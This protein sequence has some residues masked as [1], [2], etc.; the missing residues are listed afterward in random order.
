M[1][2]TVMVALLALWP[3]APISPSKSQ[4]SGVRHGEWT[5]ASD[6]PEERDPNIVRRMGGPSRFRQR[7]AGNHGN[8][9]ICLST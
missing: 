3:L 7:T 8:F 4:G 5:Q 9:R 6:G 1:K 2:R